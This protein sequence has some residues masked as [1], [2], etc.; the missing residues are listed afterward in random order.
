MPNSIRLP[1]PSPVS[2]TNACIQSLRKSIVIFSR[3]NAKEDADNRPYK[4][5]NRLG[6]RHQPPT[7]RYNA[8]KLGRLSLVLLEEG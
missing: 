7:N 5:K 1:P 2:Q 6:N 8:R 3:I 4:Y